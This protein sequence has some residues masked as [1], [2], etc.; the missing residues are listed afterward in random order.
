MAHNLGLSN[1][2]FELA[3]DIVW[4]KLE[5]YDYKVKKIKSAKL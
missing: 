4:Q 1:F 5:G 2:D 3:G